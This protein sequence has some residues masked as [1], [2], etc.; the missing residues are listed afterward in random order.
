MQFAFA[1]LLSRLLGQNRNNSLSGTISS[2]A[3]FVEMEY[4]G[5]HLTGVWASPV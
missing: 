1:L 3:A 2:Q 5:N 4:W